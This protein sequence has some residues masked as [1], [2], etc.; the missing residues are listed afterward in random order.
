MDTDYYE[1]NLSYSM[2]T[3]SHNSE[4]DVN[5]WHARLGHIGQNRIDRLVKQGL[6]PNYDK[7]DLFTCEHCLAGKATRKPFGK[8]TRADFPLQLVHSDICGPNQ[9]QKANRKWL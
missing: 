6:L 7:V 3:S 4:L 1:C 5:L 2:I 9:C 8:G